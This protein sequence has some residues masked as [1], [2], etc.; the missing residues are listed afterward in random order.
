M[1]DVDKDLDRF[2]SA[3]LT[4]VDKNGEDAAKGKR[5]RQATSMVKQPAY[6]ARTEAAHSVNECNTDR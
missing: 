5:Q 3:R 1:C 4:D 6:S 2:R